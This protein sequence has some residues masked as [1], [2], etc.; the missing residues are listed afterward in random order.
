LLAAALLA[1]ALLA[2]ALLA[3]ALLAAVWV[4][5][6]AVAFGAPVAAF[7]PAFAGPPVAGAAASGFA[8]VLVPALAFASETPE[9][10]ATSESAAAAFAPSDCGGI[11]TGGPN[12]PRSQATAKKMPKAS[13]KPP[14]IPPATQSAIEAIVTGRASPESVSIG[15]AATD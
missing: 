3:A 13:T 9:L 15:G 10:A 4:A 14:P 7:P 2:A 12:G 8:A 6:A 11:A 1:A 5:L